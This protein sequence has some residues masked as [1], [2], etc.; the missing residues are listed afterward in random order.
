MAYDEMTS[1]LAQLMTRCAHDGARNQGLHPQPSFV[2]SRE[3][4][5][6]IAVCGTASSTIAP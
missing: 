2:M 4:G 6:I 5:E 3:R 1:L